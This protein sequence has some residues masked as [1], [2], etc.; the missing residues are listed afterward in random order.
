MGTYSTNFKFYKPASSEFVDVE[1]QLNRNWDIADRDVRRLLEWEYSNLQYPSIE[2]IKNRSKFFKIYSNSLVSYFTVSG[3]WQDPKVYVSPWIEVA[4]LGWISNDWI[5]HPQLPVAYRVIKKVGG[6][7]SEVEWTGAFQSV[8]GGPMDID[9]G[10]SSQSLI[11]AGTIPAGVCPATTTYWTVNAGNTSV[12][13]SFARITITNAGEIQYYRYGPLPSA[14]VS[15]ENR[16]ELTGI[17]Y[18]VEATGT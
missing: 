15:T 3:W 8:T 2:N 1:A 5:Q 9:G 18:S 16:V 13:Y 10:M 7:I 12:N 17:S 11:L 4:K 14:G 6:A